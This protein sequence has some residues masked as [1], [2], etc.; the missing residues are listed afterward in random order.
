MGIWLR[1][2]GIGYI[3]GG[4]C[5]SLVFLFIL[6]VLGVKS[7]I[8]AMDAEDFAPVVGHLGGWVIYVLLGFTAAGL[9]VGIGLLKM[10]PW[11]WRLAMPLSVGNLF[12]LP[13]GTTHGLLAARRT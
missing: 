11:S 7:G 3:L 2:L 1:I 10:S 12:I 6:V 4:L 5:H 13:F 9:P 8:E